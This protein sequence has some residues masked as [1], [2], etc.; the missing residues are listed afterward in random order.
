[1]P[2][3]PLI[4]Y[5]AIQAETPGKIYEIYAL[6]G[7]GERARPSPPGHPRVRH[8]GRAVPRHRSGRRRNLCRW[9]SSHA[10]SGPS[11]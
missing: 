4:I 2:A 5:A 1:M 6:A 9:R 10:G 8:R 11:L 3:Q 7:E